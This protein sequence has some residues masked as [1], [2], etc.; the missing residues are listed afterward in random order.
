MIY[1]AQ[2]RTTLHT[3]HLDGAHD[4]LEHQTRAMIALRDDGSW[5]LRYTDEENGGQTALQGTDTWMSVSREGSIVSHLLFR[6]GQQTES[7]YRT[8]QGEFDM[9]TFATAY[10]AEVSER[11][12]H[13]SLHYDLFLSGTLTTH[14]HLEV[15][16]TRQ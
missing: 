11:T 3:R 8:P 5:A 2:F 1:P 14:N 12:G 10:S 16:W 6:L 9:A 15:K 13:I 4:V 7:V